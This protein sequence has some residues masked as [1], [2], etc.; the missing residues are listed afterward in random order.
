MSQY[1]RVTLL[2]LLPS[3]KAA[4]MHTIRFEG[5]LDHPSRMKRGSPKNRPC[6]V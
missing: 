5:R 2:M 3:G 6:P 1:E 4:N